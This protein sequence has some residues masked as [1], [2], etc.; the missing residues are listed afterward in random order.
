M[1]DVL[2]V[3]TYLVGASRFKY[4]LYQRDIAQTFQYPIVGDGVFSLG[5]VTQYGHLHAVFGVS[6]YIPF[7][8]SFVIF[9]DTPYQSIVFTFGG[10]VV[11]LKSQM[12]LG[13]GG[14]GYQEQALGIFVYTVD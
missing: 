14:L 11:E 5:G 8:G 10:L 9:Y 2:H 1:P 3:D 12:S 7:Y 13:I 6:S 4:T